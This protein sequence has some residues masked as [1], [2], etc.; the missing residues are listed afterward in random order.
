VGTRQQVKT[1]SMSPSRVPSRRRIGEVAELAKVTTRT[2]RYWQEIGLLQPS[3]QRDTGE[4]LY[5]D[6]DVERAKRIRELQ[7]LLG[8]S[9]AE[10]RVVLNT[11]DV[12]E[13]LRAAY[14]KEAHPKLQRRLLDEAM[15]ANDD[16][17]L[18]LNETI[19]RIELF[20]D[21]RI[22]KGKRMRS[23]AKELDSQIVSLTRD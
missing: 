13:R 21:E 23:R 7:E 19:A 14:K 20:R 17:L 10:I 9:L 22:A 16:L 1:K 18:Q 3:A 8:L 5:S 4:R 12:V 2:L 15:Y 11:D 6:A